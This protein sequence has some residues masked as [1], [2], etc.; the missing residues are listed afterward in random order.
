MKK[1]SLKGNI[2]SI[3]GYKIPAEIKNKIEEYCKQL[4]KEELDL[5]K[6]LVEFYKEDIG[7]HKR[8]SD[9]KHW[10]MAHRS[11]RRILRSEDGGIRSKAIAFTG[12]VFGDTG[13]IDFVDLMKKKA[14]KV[15]AIDRERAIAKHLTDKEGN[16]LD[17]R[18]KVDFE[19][20]PRYLEPFR[21]D[22]H[23]WSRTLYGIAGRGNSWKETKFF[24]LT[25]NGEKARTL[26]SFIGKPV[27]FRAT[28]RTSSP[29][30]ELNATT[31][32]NLQV[33]D[34][35]PDPEKLVRS[36]GKEIYRLPDLEK[37]V[38]LTDERTPILIEAIVHSINPEPNPKTNN[39]TILLD[40]EDLPM[41]ALG[42]Y[43]YMPYHIPLDFKEDSEVIFLA[44]LSRTSLGGKE[45]IVLN[46]L[47][48][49]SNPDL[50][51]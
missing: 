33:I 41:D 50:R 28:E 31:V 40:D 5:Y 10:Q 38:E 46:G 13:V 19:E 43:C 6:Q 29:Y 16:P 12:Y 37:V 3:E 14:R 42:I 21:E 24:K 25:F 7:T 32:T 2:K 1:E 34:E 47:G 44:T 35:M 15:Y 26:G 20:N 49:Y 11:L 48:Y 27:T 23:S 22:D 51:K 30:Y 8:T 36:C 17:T 4:G 39:R 45:R 18:E 9:L